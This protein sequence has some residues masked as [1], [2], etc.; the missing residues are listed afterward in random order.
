V[1]AVITDS[2]LLLGNVYTP[3]HE[4]LSLMQLV[5]DKFNQFQNLNFF[6]KRVKPF[7]PAGRNQ[8]ENEAKA[9]DD[10][11]REMLLGYGVPFEYVTGD[12]RAPDFIFNRV[13]HALA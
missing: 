3:A 9:L 13:I 2:P 5:L 6:I 7:N 4:P 11:I 1:R 8:N 12:E 10:R